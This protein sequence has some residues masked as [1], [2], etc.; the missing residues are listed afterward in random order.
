[1]AVGGRAAL[2]DVLDGPGLP[3]LRQRISG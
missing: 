1:M 2:L 3:L